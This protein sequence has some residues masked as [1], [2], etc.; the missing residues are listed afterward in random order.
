MARRKN[1]APHSDFSFDNVTVADA[2]AMP[3][4]A[5]REEKP[6][7]LLPAVQDSLNSSRPKVLPNIP[8]AAV[9]DAQNYLRRAAIKLNCGIKI[10]PTS[11][12]NDTYDVHFLAQHEKRNRAY[13]V[14]EV[15]EWA[16]LQ[17]YGDDVLYPRVARHVSDAFREAHGLKV[18]KRKG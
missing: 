15:R 6:N 17:G 10:R 2:E 11:N 3:A 4:R 18:N 13:T 9:K 16:V 14:G 7:P 8:A 12:G 1:D 5:A